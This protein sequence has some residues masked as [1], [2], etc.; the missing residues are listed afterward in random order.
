[1]ETDCGRIDKFVS[2]KFIIQI[3]WIVRI[4]AIEMRDNSNWHSVVQFQFEHKSV[5]R[6]M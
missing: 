3:L 6:K 5:D 4:D 2:L 1:M